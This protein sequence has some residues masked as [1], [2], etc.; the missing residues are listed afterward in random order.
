MKKNVVILLSIV[1]SL[2]SAGFSFA[3]DSVD[4][5]SSCPDGKKLVS[6]LDGNSI[7]CSCVDTATMDETVPQEIAD[8]ESLD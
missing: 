8:S 3:E 5:S 6:F 7:S 1:F 2:C 4:C